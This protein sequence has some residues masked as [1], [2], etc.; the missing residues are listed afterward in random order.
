MNA[1][2][3]S[4]ILGNLNCL[5]ADDNPSLSYT[6]QAE[7]TSQFSVDE[8]GNV[9]IIKAMDFEVEQRQYRFMVIISDGLWSR[10]VPC[11]FALLGSN[12]HSPRFL[13]FGKSVFSGNIFL[14]I[15]FLPAPKSKVDTH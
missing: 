8:N 3:T 13:P 12:E 4:H 2:T 11:T 6:M 10:D 1:G 15:M 7:M 14:E 9:A 5:D